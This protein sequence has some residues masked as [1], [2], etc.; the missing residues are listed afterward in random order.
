MAE[1]L[2]EFSKLGRFYDRG[3]ALQVDLKRKIIQ[4][5]VEDGG[6][7]VTG[8]FPGSFSVIAERNRVKHDTVRKIWKDLVDNGN[9]GITERHT[10]GVKHIQQ[11]DVDFIRFLKTDRASMTIGELHKHISEHCDIPG[12]TSNS[13]IQRELRNMTD[14]KWTWKKLTRP[15]A[16]KF[17]PENLN[18]CHWDYVNYISTVDP[19]KLKFFDESGIKL[20]DVGRPNYGHSLCGTPAVEIVRYANS[21]NVTLN[22]MCGLDGIVYANTVDGN[23]NSFSFL[24][25]FEEASSVY[26]PDGKPAFSYGDHVIIDN[27]P[28]HHHRAGQALGEWLDE[29]GCT[30]VYLPTYSPEFNPAENVFNKLKTILRRFEYRELLKDSLHVAVHEAL[31]EI[32][33]QDMRGFFAFFGYI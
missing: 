3:R 30:A 15:V 9:A 16:E 20:P 29:I 13:A 26:L 21:P 32:T 24:S 7:F 6:D 19:Y 18:Y 1:G 25:F 28:I 31:K 5:I 27:A 8:F 14:G 17:T 2:P 10:A 23:S 22:L 12:G 4:D 33:S 11:D